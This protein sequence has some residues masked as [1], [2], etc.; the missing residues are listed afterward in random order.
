MCRL[1][2]AEVFFPPTTSSSWTEECVSSIS[3]VVGSWRCIHTCACVCVFISLTDGN[4]N[5]SSP[6]GGLVFCRHYVTLRRARGDVLRATLPL[7][8]DANWPR[9]ECECRVGVAD[10][11][12]STAWGQPVAMLVPAAQPP[13]VLLLRPQCSQVV[14]QPVHQLFVCLFF[15]DAVI[16]FYL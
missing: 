8:R 7:Q 11:G 15:F 12:S 9:A 10:S 13:T 16:L 3:A 1:V 14:H 5:Q 2:K 4:V 6:T